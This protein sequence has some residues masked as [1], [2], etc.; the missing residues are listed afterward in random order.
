MP[1]PQRAGRYRTA[2]TR[3]RSVGVRVVAARGQPGGSVAAAE[4]GGAEQE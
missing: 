3:T 2:L 4:V 1:L